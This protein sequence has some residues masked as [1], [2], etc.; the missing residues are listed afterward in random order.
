MKFK[1][2]SI[3][4]FVASLALLAM[5]AGLTGQEQPH[6]ARQLRHYRVIDLGT[7][8]GT[9]SYGYGINNFGWV[10]GG[11]ATKAQTNGL[12]Q[13]GFLWFGPGRLINIGT[14]GGESSEAGG[15]NLRGESPVVSETSNK[16]PNE[17]DF[18]Q[19]GTHAQCLAAIWRYGQLTPLPPFQGGNNSQAYWINNGGQ[20]VGFAENGINDSSCMTA[21]AFQVLHFEAAIWGPNGEIRELSPLP[22]DEVGFAL[23][24]NDKGQAVGVTGLCSNTHVPPVSPYNGGPHAVLWEKDGTP[25]DLGSLTQGGSGF[26]V[27]AAINDLG[28]VAGASEAPDGTIHPFLWTKETGMQDLGAFT[29]A[30]V[31]GIPCCNT[32]NNRGEAVGLTA[33]SN[34]NLRAFLW[35]D[36]AREDLNDLVSKDSPL[37]LQVAASIND[38]GEIVG[39]G[40]VKS[41][42]PASNPPA[43]ET[44][45]SACTEVHAFLAI[46]CDGDSEFAPADQEATPEGPQVIVPEHAR[47]L[48]QQRV[49]FG[50]F[51]V[52]PS[53]PE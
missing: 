10:S 49:P 20:V 30:I 38:S 26:N 22:G 41:S 39:N 50:P 3:A 4:L 35:R 12:S 53:E 14:L 46:P 23:G 29:G 11:A 8:G 28:Q 5:P 45:Q 19:F 9:Y 2:L 33:D 16:D 47:K 7:L 40:V 37:Y 51:R 36:G 34:F 27:P 52:R 13:T 48:L 24:I 21:T 42:C 32:L 43:W 18:C 25:I 1:L 6:Q 31:T 17:E 15:P 44:N